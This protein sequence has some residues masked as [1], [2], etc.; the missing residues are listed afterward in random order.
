M[1]CCISVGKFDKYFFAVLIGCISCF[2]NR[3]LNHYKSKLFNNPIIHNIFISISK[4]FGIIP[5]L[6]T[7][8]LYKDDPQIEKL[9][10]NDITQEEIAN[11]TK[12]IK[13]TKW[14]YLFLSAIAYLANQVT[15]ISSIKIKSNTSIL[16]IVFSSLFYYLFFKN[17]LY[18][19]HYLSGGLIIILG[20]TIDLILG[21]LQ[22]DLTENTWIFFLRVLRE[23][24]YSLSSNIDKYAMEKKFISVY[25]LLF[26]N[27]V[28]TVIILGIF[29]I[30]DYFFIHIDK[31]K[32]YFGEF[33]V[34]EL[35]IALGTIITQ[36]SLKLSIALTNKYFSPCHIFIIF[37]F[38]Q[39]G[40][41][42]DTK[43]FEFIWKMIVVIICLLFILF[44]SLI[45]N[46]IF[47][48]NVCGL[49]DN[50]K[51]NISKRAVIDETDMMAIK[52]G[53]LESEL[54]EGTE[55]INQDNDNMSNK[56]DEGPEKDMNINQL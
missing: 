21:N 6:M 13:R 4:L 43:Y 54:S 22:K 35:L 17:K 14:R 27:G 18:M 36:F 51:K 29:A 12:R 11:E 38:G 34:E 23:A 15:Y 32:E 2:L 10:K 48:I 16:N 19:H 28:F 55:L 37:V 26:S 39:L 9:M 47:E 49:S 53:T 20:I 31:Y 30:F 5:Y 25:L 40:V 24:I 8:K 3:F 45:F 56:N 1:V 7:R 46:E 41:Y 50:T 33:S 42:V 52:K 44:L